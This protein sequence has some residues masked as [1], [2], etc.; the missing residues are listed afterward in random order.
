MPQYGPGHADLVA[1]LRAD[2]PSTIAVAGNYLDGIGVPA[3]IGAATRAVTS[4][5]G[6]VEAEVA[7]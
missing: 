3:C 7:R 6:A 5:L 1:E 4:V 2:L